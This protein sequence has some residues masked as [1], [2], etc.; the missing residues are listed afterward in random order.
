MNQHNIEK[1]HSMKKN[2][3]IIFLFA[4]LNAFGQIFPDSIGI[5]DGVQIPEHKPTKSIQCYNNTTEILWDNTNTSTHIS[6]TFK[7]IGV[8]EHDVIQLQCG[9]AIIS[10]SGK[11]KVEEYSDILYSKDEIVVLFICPGDYKYDKLMKG[12]TYELFV[13][14]NKT[15]PYGIPLENSMTKEEIEII[16]NF[17]N[18]NLVW[19][20]EWREIRK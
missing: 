20:I 11:F 12:N 19:A 13:S 14:N 6:D 16:K 5:I 8:L 1:K 15:T 9:I 7:L 2:L 18:G 17:N 3:L 10:I 4:N